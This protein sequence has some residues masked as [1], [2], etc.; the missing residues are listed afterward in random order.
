MRDD[1][2]PSIVVDHDVLKETFSP[3]TL[4]ARDSQLEQILCCLLPVT[5]N[6]KPIH[7]WLHGKPGTGKTTTA[8]HALRHIEEK[9]RIKSVIINCWEKRTFY[10]ILDEMTSQLRILGADEHRTS[11]KLERLRSHLKEHPFL[12]VLDE[13]DQIKNGELSTVLYNLDSM[14]NAGLICI[15]GSMQI[16]EELEERVRSRLNPHTIFF[17]RYSRTNL[18]D[19]LTYRAQLALAPG[20]WTRLALERIAAA[21]RGDARAAI[22]MLHKTVVLADHRRLDKITTR[23]LE[24]QLS[25]AKE[26]EKSA[27]LNSLTQDHRI[28]FKIVE[29]KCQI[30]SGDLWQEYQQCCERLKKKPLAARTFYDYANR[31]VQAGLVKCERA[32]VKGKVMLF[33][34]CN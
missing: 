18:L 24:E 34:P 32:R 19:I 2:R 31:L 11:F 29:R 12:V 1:G 10:E 6:H 26:A 8:I 9:G 33:K 17:P 25:A 20:S 22:R 21:A 4:R 30:L 7:T 28:L 5:K 23:A 3:E 27:I 13:V 16:L 15:S 14:L